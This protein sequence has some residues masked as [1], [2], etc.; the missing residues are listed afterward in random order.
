VIITLNFE[1]DTPTAVSLTALADRATGLTPTGITLPA[2]M[3]A[4]S[5][6]AWHFFF[7]GFGAIYDYTALVTWSDTSTESFFGS[8]NNADYGLSDEHLLRKYKEALAAIAGNQSYEINGRHYTR[9]E[10]PQV[11]DTI[12][13]LEQRIALSDTS[14]D[15]GGTG[16]ILADFFGDAYAHFPLRTQ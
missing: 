14:T 7:E 1:G 6:N 16:I 5:A 9:A 15:E 3:T 11:R 4:G 8:V 10:L 12:A 13:W 2:A